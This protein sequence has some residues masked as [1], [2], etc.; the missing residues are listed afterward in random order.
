[1]SITSTTSRLT[2]YY[3]RHGLQATISRALLGAKRAL[4]SNRMVVFFCDLG[5]QA[6][7]PVK[8]PDSMQIDRLTKEADISQQDFLDITSYWNAKQAERNIHERFAKGASLWLIKSQDRVAGYG[9]TLQRG[10]IEPYYFPL[11]SGDI[12]LFDFHVFPQYRGQG[13]NP[14]LVTYIL[15]SLATNCAGRAFIEAAEW[16]HAQLS[17]LQKTPFL[18]LGCVR[19]VR[20]FGHTLSWW[21]EMKTEKYKKVNAEQGD[22]AFRGGAS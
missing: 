3:S 6:T 21:S 22:C 8:V 14:L 16:N 15:H 12:H 20:V 7:R 10:T 2:N 11:G 4:F 5:P 17:S 13:I 18:R 19:S 1:M 9:W